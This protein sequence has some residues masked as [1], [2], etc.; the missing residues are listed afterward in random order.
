MSDEQRQAAE[1]LETIRTHQERTQRAA[2]VPWWGYAGMFVL[3]AGIT[4]TNDF[5]DVTVAKLIAG[6]TLVALVAVLVMMF[7]GRSA[8]LSRV[9]GV[10]ARQSFQ[11]R[12]LLAVAVVAGVGVWVA[13]RFGAGIVRG[14]AGAVGLSQYP[15]T[16]AGV[17]FGAAFT[18]L[19]ALG[20]GLV[21]AAQ[22]RADR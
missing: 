13:S 10:Q 2:R 9:R 17:V 6:V 12:A 18:A 7:V 16:V 21:G 15:N 8:P 14:I 22:R 1:A 20:R 4:A 5:A 3:T 11:P 19:F